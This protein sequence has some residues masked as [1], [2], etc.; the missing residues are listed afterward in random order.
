MLNSIIRVEERALLKRVQEKYNVTAPVIKIQ[1]QLNEEF[2]N[3]NDIS[4]PETV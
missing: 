4:E 1:R 3:N 2:S